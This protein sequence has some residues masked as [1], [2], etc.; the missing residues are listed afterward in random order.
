MM[1]KSAGSQHLE[2]LKSR[3]GVL[4]RMPKYYRTAECPFPR[5]AIQDGVHVPNINFG[6]S[7]NRDDPD[8][9]RYIMGQ[10]VKN[11]IDELGEKQRQELSTEDLTEFSMCFTAR[12]CGGELV[13][14]E[15]GGN[16]K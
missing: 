15:K 7:V 2:F 11:D 4:S 12:S 5:V 16:N 10:E 9:W 3:S 1:M 6:C 14:R 8:A 13:I